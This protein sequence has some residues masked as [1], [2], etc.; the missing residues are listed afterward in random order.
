MNA[1]YGGKAKEV[2]CGDKNNKLENVAIHM[3]ICTPLAT[4]P[5][6]SKLTESCVKELRKDGFEIWKILIEKSLKP[7]IIIASFPQSV[8]KNNKKDYCFE[9]LKSLLNL[10]LKSCEEIILNNNKPKKCWVCSLNNKNKYVVLGPSGRRPFGNFKKEEKYE[11]GEKI[12]KT[13]RD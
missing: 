8:I 10:N 12:L 5:T 6:W 7:D 11:L 1:T 2:D 9:K 3:D 4:C 13:I